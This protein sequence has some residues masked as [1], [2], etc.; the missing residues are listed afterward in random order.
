MRWEII[1]SNKLTCLNK[2]SRVGDETILGDLN[3]LIVTIQQVEGFGYEFQLQVVADLETPGQAN[4]GGSIIRSYQRVAGDSGEPVV[5]GVAI[6]VGITCHRRAYRP[7][8]AYGNDSRS[9]PVVGPP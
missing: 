6:L 8:A 1:D 9:F 7:A 4:V 2:L 3:S 5:G